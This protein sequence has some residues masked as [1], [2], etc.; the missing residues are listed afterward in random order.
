MLIFYVSCLIFLLRNS[1]M[2]INLSCLKYTM[3]LIWQIYSS[4]CLYTIYLTA[5]KI[6]LETIPFIFNFLLYVGIT[7]LCTIWV[8]CPRK[9]EEGDRSPWASVYELE[10]NPCPLEEQQEIL[11]A[12][13]FLQPISEHSYRPT[14]KTSTTDVEH[15]SRRN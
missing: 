14:E 5:G 8:Q 6:I 1:S 10:S 9:P 7:C 13:Q 15:I 3:L 12:E 11:T 4:C 2:D